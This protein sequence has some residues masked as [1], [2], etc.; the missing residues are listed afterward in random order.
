MQKI[1][2]VG[3]GYVGNAV[4]AAFKNKVEIVCVDTDPIKN[5]HSFSDLFTTD[6]I[7]I[8]VPSPANS[9]GSCDGSILLDIMA[10]LQDYNK[11]II[12]K[13]TAVPSIYEKLVVHKNLVHIPE[14][15]TAAN[16]ISDY[17]NE[18]SSI[19]GGS[20]LDFQEQAI[21]LTRVGQTKLKSGY[22]CTLKEAAFAKYVENCFLAT[23]V[24]F[25]NEMAALAKADN[26][27]WS[28]ISGI[29]Q[30]DPRVGLSHCNVPGP[31]GL[32]GFGGH[33]FPKDTSAFVEYSRSLQKELSILEQ[34]IK[35]NKKLRNESN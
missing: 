8:C 20:D 31:D 35:L 30:K 22:L 24:V 29:L 27:P 18:T 6:A 11:L 1:G 5:T 15:L 32:Y 28:S 2:I 23:K 25:M 26:I 19:I 12:S 4:A 16:S 13:T 7:F 14:F 33:C 34:A 9:D 21:K 3:L 10:R 17:A